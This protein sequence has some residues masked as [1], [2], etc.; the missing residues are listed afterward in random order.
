M[1]WCVCAV[2]TG[3]FLLLLCRAELVEWHMLV[4]ASLRQEGWERWD[5]ELKA[6][7]LPALQRMEAHDL[8]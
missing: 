5:K 8:I 4:R 2:H 1:C 3:A 6:H 7:R